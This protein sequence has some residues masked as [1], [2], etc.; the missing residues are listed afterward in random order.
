MGRAPVMANPGLRS[1]GLLNGNHW[2]LDKARHCNQQ[3]SPETFSRKGRFTL[4]VRS[5]ATM[6]LA[7]L[8]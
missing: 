5:N 8:F 3:G 2:H 4:S 7:I 1:N 6:S